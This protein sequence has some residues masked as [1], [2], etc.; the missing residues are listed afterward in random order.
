MRQV[1]VALALLLGA[2]L[3]ASAADEKFVSK[4]GKFKIQFPDGGKVEKDKKSAGGG[5]DM[6]FAIVK[7]GEKAYVAMYMDLPE[8]AKDIPAKMILD[9]AEKGSVQQSGGKIESSKDIEFGKEKYPGRD[10]VADKDG[11]K[12]K[13]RV[14]IVGTR[15]YVIAVGGPK[16][17]ATSKEGTKFLESFEITK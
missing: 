4:D 1:L 8:A 13:T 5:I 2:A 6:I 9:G 15:V 17:F 12:I 10:F 16:D 3:T 11:N 14:V 7:D